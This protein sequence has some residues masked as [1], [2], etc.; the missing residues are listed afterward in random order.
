M[1][2]CFRFDQDDVHFQCKL[3]SERCTA[4]NNKGGRCKNQVVIGLPYC[5]V[6]SK[7]HLHLRVQESEIPGAGKGVFAFSRTGAGRVFDRQ[8]FICEYLGEVLDGQEMDDRYGAG[9]AVAPYAIQVSANRYIDGAC[10]RGIAGVINHSTQ[11]NVEFY[12][13]RGT[14]RMRAL[15]NI[16]HGTE[17]K[18]NYG[19]QYELQDNHTTY[20][21]R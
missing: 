13:Y 17:L 1:P 16:N 8:Q 15:R 21:C 19:G 4:T 18:V 7:Q 12:S 10:R 20:N 14:I 5:H 6:H 9:D 2:K 3:A 11:P